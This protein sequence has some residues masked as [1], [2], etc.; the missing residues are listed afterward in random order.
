LQSDLAF[1]DA[2]AVLDSAPLTGLA[3]EPD[4]AC[5][6]IDVHFLSG[7]IACKA[8]AGWKSYSNGKAGGKFKPGCLEQKYG[9][10]RLLTLDSFPDE[11]QNFDAALG[12]GSPLNGIIYEQSGGEWEAR[13]YVAGHQDLQ[14]FW[15][16]NGTLV[17]ALCYAPVREVL[18]W[19]E[20]GAWKECHISRNDAPG[21]S[22]SNLTLGTRV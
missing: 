13:M 4:E 11:A 16:E 15:A 6:P 22:G 5:G 19:Y 1:D 17:Y 10:L 9:S 3:L 8:I 7:T 21:T 18:S 2:V 14:L 20:S 12:D